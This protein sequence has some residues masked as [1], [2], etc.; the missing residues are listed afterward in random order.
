VTLCPR[1]WA[2]GE[3]TGK[4]TRQR[5]PHTKNIVISRKRQKKTS[6]RKLTRSPPSKDALANAPGYEGVYVK[7]VAEATRELREYYDDHTSIATLVISSHGDYVS[8]NFKVGDQW[9]DN[10]TTDMDRSTITGRTNNH[11]SHCSAAR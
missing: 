5:F 8:N 11:G 2:S 10:S 1:I 7:N 6:N 3:A 9:I 4:R